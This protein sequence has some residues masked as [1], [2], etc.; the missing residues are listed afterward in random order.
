MANGG[1]LQ[2]KEGI[3]ERE[4]VIKSIHEAINQMVEAVLDPQPDFEEQLKSNKFFAQGQAGLEKLRW[5]Y[6]S[7]NVD[8]AA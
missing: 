7:G 1:Y 5:D 8:M 2:T 4:K 6:R 3:Q